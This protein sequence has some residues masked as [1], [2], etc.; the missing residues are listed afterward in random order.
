V[1]K[2]NFELSTTIQIN[3]SNSHVTVPLPEARISCNR[4]QKDL[5]R[6]LCRGERD[7][8]QLEIRG[9][10]KRGKIQG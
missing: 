4:N 7:G 2:G 6:K 8:F 9:R 5:N 3:F 10:R 1:A